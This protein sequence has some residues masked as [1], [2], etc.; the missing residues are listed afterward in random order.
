MAF[1]VRLCSA[2]LAICKISTPHMGENN[3]KQATEDMTYGLLCTPRILCGV[4]FA[5]FP[6]FANKSS[7]QQAMKGTRLQPADTAIMRPLLVAWTPLTTKI[8]RGLCRYSWPSKYDE[9][10][11]S[12]RRLFFAVPF[13][14]QAPFASDGRTIVR[15]NVSA[16][17]KAIDSAVTTGDDEH[18]R[19]VDVC[20][21]RCYANHSST[22]LLRET[23]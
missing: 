23:F 3:T 18:T 16:G 4:A 7:V 8:H 15:G 19:R 21:M 17:L 2:V 1:P 9:K 6:G 5:F 10:K 13:S 20:Y 22:G 12:H 11:T 14:V